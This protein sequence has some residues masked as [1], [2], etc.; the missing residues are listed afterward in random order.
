M[1]L[2]ACWSFLRRRAGNFLESHGSVSPWFIL[3]RWPLAGQAQG[4][5][6][7]H[8]KVRLVGALSCEQFVPCREGPPSP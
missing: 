6:S 2:T 3:P 1:V 8:S 5:G 7:S 4:V